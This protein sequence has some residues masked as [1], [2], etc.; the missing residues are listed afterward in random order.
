MERREESVICPGCACLC[1]DLDLILEDDR[2]VAVHNVCTWGVGK[3][4]T[5]K[6]L[7]PKKE[8]RRLNHPL[9]RRH[10][11]LEEVSYEAA[12][13]EAAAILT[14]ARRPVIYGLTSSGSRAQEAALALA[15]KLK[16]RLEPADLAFMAPYYQ[17]LQ[18][19]GLLW[20]PLEVI[21]DEADTLVY[22]GANPLHSCPRHV[23]RHAVFARGRYT[24]LGLEDRRV[25]AVDLYRTE[26]AKFCHLYLCLAP[27][28][29][30]ALVDAVTASLQGGPE[31]RNP[32]ARQLTDFLA[33]A[34]YGVIF[35]GRGVAYGGAD[36]FDRLAGLAA[37]LNRKAPFVLFPLPGDF[38]AAG[39]YHL[40][41]RELGSP[42][43]P[44]FAKPPEEQFHA[45]PLDFRE[46]DALLVTGADLFWLLQT[47]QA[48]D[49][50]ERRVPIVALGPFADRTTAQA[51]V[52][53]PVALDGI[54]TAE[55]AHRLDGLP[56][57]LR[58]V[59]PAPAPATHQVLAD[60]A[61]CL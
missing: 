4:L 28:Q 38:N 20:A 36:L 12:L 53:L 8:R 7:R 43:A 61:L 21:R 41:L 16:A 24:A 57:F 11:R 17:A 31:P 40:L 33:Q 55:I 18:K 42:F 44:D 2:P 26:L 25:A 10:G 1:D 32:E 59:L 14:A 27:E 50:Q 5:E 48:Q 60:L 52:C 15:Q 22:W 58:P 45:E 19:H 23:V 13:T 49:L 9:V 37:V 35:C 6:R 3:F 47:E 46:V 54:E 56:V 39:L 34:S 30:L 51:Q 29:E